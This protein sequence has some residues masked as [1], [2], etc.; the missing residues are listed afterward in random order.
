MLAWKNLSI[1]FKQNSLQNFPVRAP[2]LAGRVGNFVSNFAPNC[3]NFSPAS[4]FCAT[5]SKKVAPA[6]RKNIYPTIFPPKVLSKLSIMLSSF[7]SLPLPFNFTEASKFSS[8][9]ASIMMGAP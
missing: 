6:E 3:L 9:M 2:P 7:F 5:F 4:D 8:I 1:K